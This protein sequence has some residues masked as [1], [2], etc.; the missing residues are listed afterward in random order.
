MTKLEKLVLAVAG[1]RLGESDLDGEQTFQVCE[2]IF[3]RV[4]FQQENAETVVDEEFARV[5]LELIR[6]TL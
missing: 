6:G 2:A 1:Q 5:G 3:R 4:M